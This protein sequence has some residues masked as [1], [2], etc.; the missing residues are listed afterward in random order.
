MLA[1]LLSSSS[2]A[3]PPAAARVESSLRD[4]HVLAQDEVE[5]AVSWGRSRGMRVMSTAGEARVLAVIETDD[6][7]ELMVPA[8]RMAGAQIEGTV[9]AKVLAWIP[10]EA[11]ESVAAVAGVRRVRRPI[12]ATWE[13]TSQGVALTG[14]NLMH[15]RGYSGAGVRVGVLDVFEGYA[16]RIGGELPPANRVNFRSFIQ[17]GGSGDDPHGVDVAEIITDMAPD[18]H[19]FLAAIEDDFGYSL[20]MDWLIANDVHIINHSGGFGLFGDMKG[21]GPIHPKITQAAA[22]DILYVEAAGNSARDHWEGAFTDTDGDDLHEWAPGVEAMPFTVDQAAE[23]D[24][25]VDLVWDDWRPNPV[26]PRPNTD[27]DLCVLDADGREVG[28]ARDLQSGLA[29]QVPY[30]ALS[31][32]LPKQ[33]LYRLELERVSGDDDLFLEVMLF[34]NVDLGAFAIPGSSIIAPADHREVL[35]VG[36]SGL[37][38]VVRSYSAR[39]PTNDGRLKPQLLA[40]DGVSTSSGAF[41]G[42]SAAAPHVTG[43]AALLL[44]Y[45]PTFTRRQLRDRILGRAVEL[46]SDP[47]PGVDDVYGHGRLD[48]NFAS[49]PIPEDPP[50]SGGG[51]GGGCRLVPDERLAARVELPLITLLLLGYAWHLQRRS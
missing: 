42:T 24:L 46:A 22:V 27:Y 31:I 50:S 11:I 28:C 10:L 41:F 48:A 14:A 9:A 16:G 32:R 4:L 47:M 36:A 20:A 1:I 33:G 34:P 44:E 21:N 12:R 17:G 37:A 38:D 39:G 49:G 43:A 29:G 25:R 45:R 26:N 51:G 18:V 30:E 2:S 8:L 19:L 15:S 35:A 6:A 13:A 5:A 7:A 40:P 23:L 3:A